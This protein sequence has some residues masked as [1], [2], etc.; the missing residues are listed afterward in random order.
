MKRLLAIL[1]GVV[2]AVSMLTVTALA[3]E[4]DITCRVSK[5]DVKLGETVT[6]TVSISGYEPIKSAGIALDYDQDVF[7]VVSGRWLVSNPLISDFDTEK[8]NAVFAYSKAQDINGDIFEFTLKAIAVPTGELDIQV[9][10]QLRNEENE[11]V[12]TETSIA[13]PVSVSCVEHSYGDWETVTPATCTADGK[14]VRKCTI[15]GAELESR[16][17]AAK[18]HSYG[19]WET[20]TPATCTDKGS[21][22][23][24][25]SVCKDEDIREIAALGHKYGEWETVKE[26]TCTEAGSEKRVCSVCQNEETREIAAPGHKFGEWTVEKE[27]T[28]EEDGIESRVCSVC[29]EKE[30]R[31][32]E[33]DALEAA[34][35][36]AK[37]ELNS[38]KDPEDYREEQQKELAEAIS[39][40]EAAIDAAKTEEQVADAL[41]EAKA[42]MDG[43][44]TDA[45]LAEEEGKTPE[46]PGDTEEPSDPNTPQTGDNGILI[47]LT[48]IFVLTLSGFA[49]V[50][51]YRKKHN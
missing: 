6:V 51:V 39:A 5:T 31:V 14:E 1:L 40:G 17:I 9:T 10:P 41:A 49:A 44:K 18:G 33:Y 46:K 23:R 20:V 29:Q 43:I 21:E 22:K 45:Q 4:P 27:A 38:Y 37:E 47:A 50:T 2:L 24:V 13:I 30:T 35:E 16:V 12:E 34:K 28:A 3:A 15:C 26:A 42:A 25:C 36:A 32:I 11:N 8:L 7:E 48:A 19:D